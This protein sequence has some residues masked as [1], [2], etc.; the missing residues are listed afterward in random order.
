MK[1][2]VIEGKIAR[3]YDLVGK[4]DPYLQIT[5][6]KKGKYRTYTAKEAGQCPKWNEI[7]EIPLGSREELLV[8]SIFDEDWFK[9]EMIAQATFSVMQLTE[10]DQPTWYKF[11]EIT[12]N[13][14][15]EMFISCTWIPERSINHINNHIKANSPNAAK[16]IS[17]EVSQEISFDS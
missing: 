9:D 8:F 11:K 7:F 17:D 3:N 4:M 15:A 2:H 10:T 16:T 5:T 1:I 14:I 13:N 12:E 6:L